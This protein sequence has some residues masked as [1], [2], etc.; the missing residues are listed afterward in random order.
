MCTGGRIPVVEVLQSPTLTS[1]TIASPL[2]EIA[3]FSRHRRAP[4]FP[5]DGDLNWYF[6]LKAFRLTST[7]VISH[8]D[9][10]SAPVYATAI[11]GSTFVDR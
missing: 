11:V 10:P 7:L 2:A 9:I 5:R 6:E 3:A 8:S 4:T 1:G